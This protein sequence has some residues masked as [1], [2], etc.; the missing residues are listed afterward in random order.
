MNS[1]EYSLPDRRKAA[2]AV[3][4]QGRSF[5]LHDHQRTIIGERR[6][7]REPVHFVQN[8]IGQFRCSDFMM[9]L[10]ELAQAYVAKELAFAVI[11]FG[12]AVG[13]ED[14][15]VARF[16][17]DSPLVVGYILKNAQGKSGELNAVAPAILVQKRL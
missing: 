5:H 4:F 13:M 3:P 7:L 2:R 1:A 8:A 17:R 9:L 15:N 10:D 6:A 14:Q 16:K 11:R 12:D